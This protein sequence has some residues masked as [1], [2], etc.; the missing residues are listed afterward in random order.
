[1]HPTWRHSCQSTHATRHC[2]CSFGAA[3]CR[4]YEHWDDYGA[5]STTKHGEHS[6]FLQ[7]LYKTCHGLHGPLIKLQRLLLNSC[8]RDMSWSS[9]SQPSSWMVEAPIFES[10]IIKELCELM[11]IWKVKTSPY[12]AQ[13]NGQTELAHQ[14]LMHMI[15]KLS[16]DQKADWPKH[17]PE[18]EHAYNSMRLAI[19]RYIPH[20]SMSGCQPCLPI[21]F[22]FPMIRGTEKHQLLDYYIA[23]LC[24]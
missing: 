4:F 19:N 5:G 12:H 23:K 2:H 17:L 10:N 9:E 20:Y 22:Y 14:M 15:E 24:K 8:G 6:A 7:S 13:T 18:L 16:K 21:D 11:G 3:A 1:M